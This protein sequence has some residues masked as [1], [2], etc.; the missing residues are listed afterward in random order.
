MPHMGHIANSPTIGIVIL[1]FQIISPLFAIRSM[2][3]MFFF[4]T[5]NL[6]V[7]ISNYSYLLTK[8]C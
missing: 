7:K 1:A 6:P 8:V 2:Q 5:E 4:S 3:N